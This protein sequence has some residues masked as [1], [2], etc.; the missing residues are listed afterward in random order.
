MIGLKSMSVFKETW[1]DHVSALTDAVD[2]ITPVVEFMAVTGKLALPLA[3]SCPL[4]PIP[5]AYRF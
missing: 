2:S 5:G 3:S 4:F 1:T